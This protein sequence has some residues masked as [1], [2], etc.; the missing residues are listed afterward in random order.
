[1]DQSGNWT[2]YRCS[3]FILQI[4]VG[5]GWSRSTFNCFDPHMSLLSAFWDFNPAQ[6]LKIHSGQ[7]NLQI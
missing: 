7:Q 4:L 2:G 6:Q 1:M 3:R 5:L